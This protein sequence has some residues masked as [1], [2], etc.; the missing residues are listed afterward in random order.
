VE[1]ALRMLISLES[2]SNLDSLRT[3]GG[4]DLGCLASAIPF[5]ILRNV[6]NTA[7]TPCLWRA[8]TYPS[9]PRLVSRTVENVQGEMARRLNA[10]RDGGGCTSG[11]KHPAWV[12]M[13]RTTTK[14]YD[15]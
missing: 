6:A 9:P 11:G 2:E 4:W 7:K 10:S 13:A 8:V 1:P 5:V 3:D 12:D 15:R 14:G